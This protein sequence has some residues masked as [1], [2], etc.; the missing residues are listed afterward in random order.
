MFQ[1]L[2]VYIKK[3]KHLFN[4]NKAITDIN[5]NSAFKEDMYYLSRLKN[6]YLKKHYKMFFLAVFFML[7]VAGLTASYTF[8]VQSVL[9][10]I[11]VNKD[12]QMLFWIPILILII[13][14]AKNLCSYLQGLVMG[15]IFAKIS[16]EMRADYCKH[17][18]YSDIAVS[19]SKTSA[20]VV[21]SL[22]YQVNGITNGLNGV[23]INLIRESLTII[24]LVCVLFYKNSTLAFLGIFGFPIAIVPITMLARKIR[25]MLSSQQNDIN[26]FSGMIDDILKSPKIVKAY[27]AQK[28]E[29]SRIM[30]SLNAMLTM[31]KKIIKYSGISGP[32]METIGVFSFAFV[33]WYG[34]YQVIQGVTSPGVF[35]AF[36]TSMVLAYKPAKY[37]S[38][39]Y[40]GEQSFFMHLKS[41]YQE[42]D[43]KP[44][45][46][47]A[48]DA[49]KIDSFYD[50]IV[51]E[52]V[53]FKYPNGFEA[54]K[55]LNIVIKKGQ[56]V[57]LVGKTGS[58]KST[59]IN[60]ILRF[61]DVTSGR[62]L[63]D[64]EDIRNVD[65]NS[66]RSMF[67]YIG[68]DVTLFND[69]IANNIKY[70][71][72]DISLEDIKNASHKAHA[73]EFIDRLE[74]GYDF[75]VG[76][77]GLKLS[78]GQKQRVIIARAILHNQP[79]LIMDEATS[80]L[81]SVSEKYIQDA[82]DNLSQNKTTI[83]IAHRLSTVKKSD[84]IYVMNEGNLV[85][86]GN[87]NELI[88]QN[89]FYANFY[90]TQYFE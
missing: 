54:I 68:Q 13:G 3:I 18:L 8:I 56:K 74:G 87:H 53:S 46:I 35:F 29:E 61:Y 81:D 66:L 70:N 1:V 78:G 60:L 20:D 5:K 14:L 17:F 71:K 59:I 80:S 84:I 55:N 62:I 43:N 2:W 48:P 22:A 7:S 88:K 19:N 79:C 58:G 44:K 69:T 52:D 38:G 63:I 85:E 28:F 25:R 37:L 45:V 31:Q 33:I 67:S 77:Y 15:T 12:T 24:T 49:K 86:K 32:L 57:A 89:K 83:A 4:F 41:Y 39:L 42:L 76:Q 16:N 40:I 10:K 75:N 73:D 90:N 72:T 23:L 64:G 51:F 82:I 6:S 34:G 30:M 65:I 27:N 36:L 9:D 47:S 11:F 50:S 21:V 26:S